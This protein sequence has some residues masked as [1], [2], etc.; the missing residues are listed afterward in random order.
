MRRFRSSLAPLVVSFVFCWVVADVPNFIWKSSSATT[1]KQ[2]VAEKT[3]RVRDAIR[4]F[5]NH[6]AKVQ[7]AATAALDFAQTQA[8]HAA[9]AAHDFEKRHQVSAH[10]AEAGMKSQEFLARS[11]KTA[12][13]LAV[14]SSVQLASSSTDTA[15]QLASYSKDRAQEL[16]A[17]AKHVAE[18]NRSI[19]IRTQAGDLLRRARPQARDIIAAGVGAGT[20]WLLM[21][22]RSKE[23]Q[24]VQKPVRPRYNVM[25]LNSR[26]PL[27]LASW[28]T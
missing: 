11:G 19:Q 8:R 20:S 12:L 23:V 17:K 7:S 28:H 10:V 27:S 5:Q 14:N 22:T 24:E 6:S 15:A 4:Q 26:D 13:Q 2:Q 9:T 3:D 1:E 21:Q 18:S 16:A 25:F